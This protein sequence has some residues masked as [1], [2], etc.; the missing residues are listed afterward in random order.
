MKLFDS[1]FKYTDVRTVFLKSISAQLVSKLYL[2]LD[3]TSPYNSPVA[4]VMLYGFM[5]FLCTISNASNTINV[6]EMG[7]GIRWK[8]FK[9]QFK[10]TNWR[11]KVYIYTN[12]WSYF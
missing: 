3:K 10:K 11:A 8:I 6:W 12:I 2:L 4:L 9:A 1:C 7:K 5:D